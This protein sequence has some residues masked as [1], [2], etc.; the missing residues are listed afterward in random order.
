MVQFAPLVFGLYVT[1][2]STV[3]L[4]MLI[5]LGVT[6]FS[7]NCQHTWILDCDYV[8]HDHV[9]VGRVEEL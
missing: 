7:D 1:A 5:F 6:I 9:G 2:L 3:L 8:F 4:L